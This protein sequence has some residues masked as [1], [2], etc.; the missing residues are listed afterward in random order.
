[1]KNAVQSKTWL[2]VYNNSNNM[3]LDLVYGRNKK[4][5]ITADIQGCQMVTYFLDLFPTHY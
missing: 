1:M 3:L 2:K 5:D 4:H